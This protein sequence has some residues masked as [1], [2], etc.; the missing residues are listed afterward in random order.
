M[1]V[2]VWAS[3]R[4]R[5]GTLGEPRE[6]QTGL[7]GHLPGTVGAAHAAD[8]LI[9]HHGDRPLDPGVVAAAS[10]DGRWVAAWEYARDPAANRA[11]L[12]A[13]LTDRSPRVRDVVEA[14]LRSLAWI[15]E[16]EARLL[17]GLLTRRAP[18][19]APRRCSCWPRRTRQPVRPRSGG[20]RRGPPSS[21]PPPTSS[22]TPAGHRSRLLTI[23]RPRC[24]SRS[25]TG[26]RRTAQHP[27]TRA[28]GSSITTGAGWCGPRWAGGCPST[29]M[30]RSTR[31]RASN[32]WPTC[33]GSRAA[34][35]PC[36][37]RRSWD[38]GGSGSRHSS[39]M[40][41]SR[42]RCWPACPG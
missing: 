4:E 22:A 26:R 7:I 28:S 24:G 30:W 42:W 18:T 27:L 6:V 37:C 32:C 38:R 36:P 16:E 5:V 35:V 3:V 23:P 33:A 8:V 20:W 39:L 9:S 2:E 14:A 21:A 40:G 25:P 1:P 34:R 12:F 19:C 17:E 11:A 29:P 15:S 31:D 13:L 10:A 41:A